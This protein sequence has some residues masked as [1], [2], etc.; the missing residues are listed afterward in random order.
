M[1]NPTQKA[2]S[3]LAWRLLNQHAARDPELV[4]Q[5]QTCKALWASFRRAH[6]RDSALIR[7]VSDLLDAESLLGEIRGEYQFF[8]GLQMGLELGGLDNLREFV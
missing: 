8:L 3:G 7:A 5:T 4:R 2:L 1:L 6:R